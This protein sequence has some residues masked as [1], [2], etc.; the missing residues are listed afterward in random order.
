MKISILILLFLAATGCA[1]AQCDIRG[2]VT[3][4]KGKPLAHINVSLKDSYDGTSSDSLGRFAFTT[5]ETGRH[6]LYFSAVG[7]GTDS[8]QIDISGS[9]LTADFVL[10]E[11]FNQLNAVTITAGTF[12]ASDT[13]KGVVLNSLDV[14]TTAGA[15]A[16][17]FAAL[18][19]LP[20]TQ[21][22]FSESGLFVRG[23]SAAET[24]TYF[25]GMLVK[26]PFNATVP[27]QAARGRFSPFLFKGTSFSSGGYSAQYGQ[28]LSSALLLESKDLP[29]KS[30]TGLSLLSVGAAA[31]QN[32]RFSKSALTLSSFYYNLK[33]AFSVIRQNTDWTKAP[34]QFG[35]T[36]QYKVKTS[37]TGMLKWYSDFTSSNLTLETPDATGTPQFFSNKRGNG[38]INTTYREFLSDTWK[39]E[40]GLAYNRTTDSG[41]QGADAYTRKDELWHGRLV[42]HGFIRPRFTMHVGGE[43][44]DFG[45]SE[46]LNGRY[47]GY[48]DQLT[49]AFA[50]A[51]LFAGARIAARGGLRVEH[52]SYTGTFN[53]A[54]RASLAF[55]TG[56][57]AQV[58]MA[59]GKFYQSAPEEYLVVRPLD[60]EAADHLILNFQHS[61]ADYTLRAETFYKWY[62]RLAKF[63]D[64]VYS[65][66]GYGYARGL[67]LF[68]RDKKTFKGSDY[69]VSYSFLDTKRNFADFPTLAEPVFAAR[70]TLNVVY[71]RYFEKLKTHAGATYT[72]A[73]GR[74]YFNPNNPHY[75]ADKTKAFNNFS[76]NLSYLT[77]IMKQFTIVYVSANNIPGF[78]NIYGYRYSA[79]GLNRQS[80]TPAAPRD[81]FVG[82]LMTIGDRTFTR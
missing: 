32:L 27:D 60:F 17:I 57:S 76:L 25:D 30:S 1:Y 49:S 62:D 28:A 5:T 31:D 22:A 72:F 81:L 18:Q 29:D 20:G 78:K 56:H 42:M 75:L 43:Y 35:A 23:G 24:K 15:T 63:R 80:I 2:T 38:Y 67:D 69:W 19:T 73:S 39:L 41:L 59:Y 40:S 74:S 33:P 37:G 7:V 58:S 48:S 3:S 36:V 61:N 10:R 79:D 50:E 26:N 77:N 11:G 52:S 71:K 6:V 65:N 21:T 45:R 51:E 12:E 46:S 82:I 34:E 4:A 16:D 66:G 53:I 68:W 47:R 70:H 55:K 64:G 8:L 14:A 54:P 44:F 13:K 9:V